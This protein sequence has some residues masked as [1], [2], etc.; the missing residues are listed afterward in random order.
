MW[1]SHP[2]NRPGCKPTKKEQRNTP[3]SQS[4]RNAVLSNVRPPFVEPPFEK[5]LLLKAILG[6]LVFNDGRR[7]VIKWLTGCQDPTAEL[8]IFA[9]NL[10]SRTRPQVCSKAA[11]FLEHFFPKSHIG[12]ER[13][14]LQASAL[15]PQI[16]QSKGGQG[17]S[18][19]F[20]FRPQ[21]RRRHEG[22]L[23]NNAAT[24]S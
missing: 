11:I 3:A 15:H 7:L 19:H 24:C 8:R 17:V 22:P 10:A 6:N 5:I 2:S 14:L 18:A 23:R 12:S 20:A 21:P 16:K 1:C 4:G 9:T 13:R